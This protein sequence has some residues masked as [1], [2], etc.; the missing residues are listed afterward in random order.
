VAQDARHLGDEQ[1]IL[2]RG[3]QLV[4]LGRAEVQVPKGA[5]Q[6]AQ[7]RNETSVIRLITRLIFVW[8]LREMAL[9]PE[10]CSTAQAA[11]DAQV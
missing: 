9:V 3:R 10:D 1:E 7:L 4:F 2:S 6:N 11:R 8:F 5:G